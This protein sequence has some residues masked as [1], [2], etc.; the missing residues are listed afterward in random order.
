MQLTLGLK[1]MLGHGKMARIQSHMCIP[2]PPIMGCHAHC[3]SGIIR[4]SQGDAQQLLQH[5]MFLI[6]RRV[7]NVELVEIG[8]T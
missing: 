1:Q 5:I 8:I 7:C 6:H 3:A 4:G 2:I